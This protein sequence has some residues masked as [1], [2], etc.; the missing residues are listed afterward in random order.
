VNT[1]LLFVL[2]FLLSTAALANHPLISDDAEVVDK[3]RWELELHG[4]RG[5]DRENGVKLRGMQ[6]EA[7]IAYGVAKDL[8]VKIELPYLHATID[9]G[10]ARET[11]KGRGDVEVDLKWN[12]VERDGLEL[13]LMPFATLPTG[14]DDRGLGAGRARFGLDFVAAREWGD[15][16]LIGNVGYLRNRNRIGERTSLWR[17][18]AAFLWATTER[19]KLFI[20]VGRETNPEP[21]GEGAIRDWVYGFL[22]D[23]SSSI[24][25][26]L[27][28]KN[29]L[30]DAADDRALMAGLRLRW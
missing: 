8:E 11:V 19:L 4:E 14:R 29:G 3:G 26:G 7:A 28:V 22:Y 25:F 21:A 27:G 5:R 17:A 13:T 6:V 2:G 18:S 30:S 16:E 20:D 12:F 24:D 10:S 15:F 1:V 23:V 9:D